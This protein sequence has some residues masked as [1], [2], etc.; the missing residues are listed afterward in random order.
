MSYCYRVSEGRKPLKVFTEHD[1]FKLY[2]LDVGLLTAQYGLD[3]A[4]VM[5]AADKGSRYRGGLAEN[6][7][8]QQLLA[9]GHDPYYW[10]TSS[11]AEVDFVLQFEG[12]GVVPVEV[13]SG[14]NVSARS[15][16]GYR[17]K[18]DPTLVV[19]VSAKNFGYENGI[20]SVPLYAVCFL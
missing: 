17:K 4:D 15:L 8:M 1:F 16:E 7:V 11:K 12:L 20:K 3:A 5:P 6:Y 19:R 2:L 18:Y 14:G 9:G 13:K 10:G